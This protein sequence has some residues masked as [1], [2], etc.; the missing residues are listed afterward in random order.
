M[1]EKSLPKIIAENL[2]IIVVITMILSLM[3][4]HPNPRIWLREIGA[5]FII[6]ICIHMSFLLLGA[7]FILT[8]RNTD[9]K[10]LPAPTYAPVYAE[11]GIVTRIRCSLL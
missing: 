6:V 1:P 7:L 9:G 10:D 5:N 2:G 8:A 11:K 4:F 3:E